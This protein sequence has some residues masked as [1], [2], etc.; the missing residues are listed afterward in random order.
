MKLSMRLVEALIKNN[1]IK[2]GQSFFRIQGDGIIQVLKN[3]YEPN[4]DLPYILS[5]G[6][7]SMY[8]ELESQWFTSAGCIPRYE[9]INLLG[10]KDTTLA[11][12]QEE[13][14]LQEGL[15]WLNKMVTQKQLVDGM[16]YLDI[17]LA[18]KIY[19]LDDLKIAPLLVVGDKVSA[20]QIVTRILQQHQSAT[21]SRRAYLS[22]S[23]YRLYC[24]RVR[25]D[26]ASLVQLLSL[27]QSGSKFQIK[28]YLDNNYAQ[29]CII[30]QKQLR[31]C[32]H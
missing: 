26:D 4:G 22:E 16:C 20:E 30:E 13:I 9:A 28:A 24:Q 19:W 29:N 27:I 17:A 2:K 31:W 10:L 11:T 23:D 18:G 32:N 1:F 7:M 21:E 5:I 25:E 14:L 8:S 15:P 6:L 12:D 3:E